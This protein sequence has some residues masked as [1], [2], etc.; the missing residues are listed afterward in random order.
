LRKESQVEVTRELV[1]PV[2]CEDVWE[3][4][5][6]P[7]RLEEWF[8]NDVDFDLD[9]GEGEFRWET[10]EV[11][12]AVV[13][14]AEVGRRLAIRWWDPDPDGADVSDVVFTI[15]EV[16]EGTRL[17]VTETGSDPQ[18]CAGEWSW[19]LELADVGRSRLL[20]AV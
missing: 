2:P 12:R 14:E 18:A 1:L 5:T 8:A 19:A 11:R 4:L 13:E 17:T 20:C 7:E 15:E 16:P 3:A 9:E 6:N 10:G